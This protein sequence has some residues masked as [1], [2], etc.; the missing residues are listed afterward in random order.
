MPV[1]MLGGD[2]SVLAVDDELAAF[3]FGERPAAPDRLVLSVE[4]PELRASHFQ[5][6]DSPAWHHM[7]VAHL[8]RLPGASSHMPFS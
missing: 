8:G 7:H 4:R 6:P 1:R 5:S 2:S 3:A